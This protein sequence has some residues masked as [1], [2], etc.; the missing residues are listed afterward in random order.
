ML[1]AP[2]CVAGRAALVDWG[3]GVAEYEANVEVGV[4]LFDQEHFMSALDVKQTFDL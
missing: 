4:L 2:L 1:F 3:V